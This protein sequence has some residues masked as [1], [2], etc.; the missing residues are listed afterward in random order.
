MIPAGTSAIYRWNALDD[1]DDGIS[2]SVND[3]LLLGSDADMN[4]YN[5]DDISPPARS[6]SLNSH[7]GLQ[8]LDSMASTV[9]DTSCSSNS[10]SHDEDDDTIDEDAL[11]LALDDRTNKTTQQRSYAN[12]LKQLQHMDSLPLSSK[13]DS[14]PLAVRMKKSVKHGHGN[15]YYRS[16]DA[17]KKSNSVVFAHTNTKENENYQL[18]NTMELRSVVQSHGTQEKALASIQNHRPATAIGTI[19]SDGMIAIRKANDITEYECS[20]DDSGGNRNENSKSNGMGDIDSIYM[21]IERVPTQ[22]YNE[23]SL[24]P[25][26]RVATVHS[27]G[28]YSVST[29]LG[30]SYANAIVLHN[31]IRSGEDGAHAIVPAAKGDMVVAPER[32]ATIGSDG[33]IT[34]QEIDRNS[35]SNSNSNY[36]KDRNRET[37]TEKP[38]LGMVPMSPATP[39]V[40]SVAPATPEDE[41]IPYNKVNTKGG[42]SALSS[43]WDSFQF[44]LGKS[45]S[46]YAPIP[47][48][49]PPP[50]NAGMKTTTS[51]AASKGSSDPKRP[52]LPFSGLTVITDTDRNNDDDEAE[53]ADDICDNI[54]DSRYTRSLHSMP[55]L[56]E[57]TEDEESPKHTHL[58]T[59]DSESELESP[60]SQ[61]GSHRST[62]SASNTTT[63]HNRGAKVSN[64]DGSSR[65]DEAA[66]AAATW[67]ELRPSPSATATMTPR[68]T[69]DGDSASYK[70]DGSDSST[71]NRVDHQ[72]GIEIE[73]L[74]GE[75]E[76]EADGM[77]DASTKSPPEDET[78]ALEEKECSTSKRNDAVVPSLWNS[79]RTRLGMNQP[80]S[81]D[82]DMASN[83]VVVV[84]S[85]KTIP[86]G[87]TDHLE[88]D[89]SEEIFEVL[90]LSSSPPSQKSTQ[91]HSMPYEN[92]SSNSPVAKLPISLHVETVSTT[93]SQNGSE[94]SDGLHHLG[95]V[96]DNYHQ[97]RDCDASDEDLE[98]GKR[99]GNSHGN[100]SNRR[101]RRCGS[102]RGLRRDHLAILG[103]LVGVLFGV[104]AFFVLHKITRVG[105]DGSMGDTNT[106]DDFYYSY[107]AKDNKNQDSTFGIAG[108]GSSSFP[109][110]TNVGFADRESTTEEERTQEWLN[111]AGLW[112][113]DV[114]DSDSSSVSQPSSST[115]DDPIVSEEGNANAN[116]LDNESVGDDWTFTDELFAGENVVDDNQNPINM[117]GDDA[118]DSASDGSLS[119]L[120]SNNS[121]NVENAN[122]QTMRVSLSPSGAPVEM[123]SV[124][125]DSITTSSPTLSPTLSPQ[126][127][128]TSSPSSE[129]QADAVIQDGSA[130]YD[131]VGNQTTSSSL[132]PSEAPFASALLSTNTPT[133]S[134]P[135]ASMLSLTS[136]PT[137]SPTSSPTAM[138]VMPPTASPTVPRTPPPIF[139]ISVIEDMDA[140]NDVLKRARRQIELMIFDDDD[141]IG[142]FL[143]L[144]FHDCVG[145]CN[146]CVD[147]TNPENNGLDKPIDALLPVVQEFEGQGLSRTDVWMLSALVASELALPFENSDLLFP[148]HWIGRQTCELQF[149]K[150]AAT[151]VAPPCGVDFFGSPTECSAKRGPHVDQPHGLIGTKSIQKL[152]EEEF[153][154]DAQQATALM[155]AHS[156]GKMAR[157]NVGFR[158]AWDLSISSLDSGYWLNLVGDPPDYFIETVDNQDLPNIP[159]RHQWRGILP[160]HD[161][162]GGGEQRT[163]AMLNVDVSL[164]KNL[165]DMDASGSV[166]CAGPGF[167]LLKDCPPT[168]D[169]DK[170]T[171][172]LPFVKK[173]NSDARGFLTDFRDV[174]NLLIDHGHN[175]LK[176]RP[177]TLCPKDR[178]C[179]FRPR[180]EGASHFAVED[181]T[182][183]PS[184]SPSRAPP[185]P[186]QEPPDGQ[187]KIWVDKMCYD[188]VGETLVVTYDHV[189][190]GWTDITI[191]LYAAEDVDE[192]E[193]YSFVIDEDVVDSPLEESLSCGSSTCH[194]WTSRGG[195]QMPTQNLAGR[196]SDYAVV[197]FAKT[198]Q[199]DSTPLKPLAADSFRLEGCDL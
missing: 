98:S 80:E 76:A 60:P 127:Y 9:E 20:N 30:D 7:L 134:S 23:E 121:S 40:T 26:S 49:T 88:G 176:P 38:R 42:D 48:S 33:T 66:E 58:P 82:Q 79:I 59:L 17:A 191:R 140:I 152:F 123:D 56:E 131:Y 136:L 69:N 31:G 45:Q 158:G 70:A 150:V 184:P 187:T 193:P 129:G 142:K 1:L 112:F 118:L 169:E 85:K 172:F 14:S 185:K 12:K 141:L 97:S 147:M 83:P 151:G 99:N 146:G 174:L 73:L 175:H 102:G 181:H 90:V 192:N 182:P 29:A 28:T 62:Y 180:S 21:D 108:D 106:D 55:V 132:S 101:R 44:R 89:N 5:P 95:S 165:P 51:D 35:N 190:E 104:A 54:D 87:D 114:S 138:P 163:V 18:R 105:R 154:F 144:V 64:R 19:Q 16:N 34:Y 71:N 4:Y 167:G 32:I 110:R 115:N 149:A 77:K 94:H 119:S 155:G 145:G 139:P 78:N 137:A 128:R 189:H 81:S 46:S 91:K 13:P 8:P 75:P 183:P 157:E 74:E 179:T 25:L 72:L 143:R 186:Y 199:N 57:V 170:A 36:G 162:S 130:I 135:T 63:N 47:M 116:D 68:R 133:T 148:M 39:S 6:K 178:V 37:E 173:Y 122:N 27:D 194:T 168:N 96:V 166:G 164:V 177:N 125:D 120:S 53:E 124:F 111:E 43:W 188:S 86:P 171:P 159:T 2:D 93:S 10:N 109:G 24:R 197:L 103:V 65:N 160:S 3:D 195:F 126:T 113:D 84:G 107:E 117:V 92:S 67:L 161:G 61:E 100:N 15:T 52:L 153:G 50:S 198:D 196:G 22:E 11:I 156:V 41:S